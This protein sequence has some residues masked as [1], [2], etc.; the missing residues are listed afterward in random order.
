MEDGGVRSIKYVALLMAEGR[1]VR[2]FGLHWSR[3]T[4]GNGPPSILATRSF[5]HLI[6]YC[7]C[8]TTRPWEA[9][10]KLINPS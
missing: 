8:I 6:Y 2:H 7:T 4:V 1:L 5:S 9:E 10:E 3:P